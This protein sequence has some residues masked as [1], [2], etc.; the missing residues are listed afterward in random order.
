MQKAIA[1]MQFKVEGQIINRNPEYNMQDRNLLER[2][3]YENMTIELGGK[4]YELS[5]KNL[6]TVDPNNPYQL[7]EEEASVMRKLKQSFMNS[8]KMRKHMRWLYAKGSLYLVRNANLMFNASMPMN[9][10]GTFK[11]VLVH[12]KEYSGKA[13]FDR[14][15]SVVRAAYF[16]NPAD[17]EYQRDLDYM[18][19]LWCG[20]DSPFFDKDKMTNFEKYFIPDKSMTKEKKGHYYTLR[21]E[22]DICIKV[23]KEFGLE[24]PN[25]HIINGHVP[26]KVAKG[27]QPVKAGGKLL[28]ID[29]GFSKAYQSETGIAGYTLIYHSRGLQ[30]V[31]HEPF[32]STQKAIEEGVDIISNRFVLEFNDNRMHVRDT[33]I[34]HELTGQIED[35]KK[36]LCAYRLGLIDEKH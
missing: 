3:N 17:E 23:L 20:P 18:W 12:G 9:E 15:D 1:V 14:V 28:V 19:Y 10:D 34:G 21:N 8:D 24:G 7:T 22:Y 13:L 29:G 4:L 36:L 16:G 25:S 2:I 31:Q 33:D 26:V 11:K 6:P 35:L 5:D 32:Q 30:L 27:E